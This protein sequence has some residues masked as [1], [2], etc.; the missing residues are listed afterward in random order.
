MSPSESPRLAVLMTCHN[1]KSQTQACLEALKLQAEFGASLDVYLVDD[2]STDGTAAAASAVFPQIN[3][4]RGDGDLYWCG[5]MRLAFAAA[6]KHNYDFYLWL[7]D[8]TRLF[9]DA[10]T[11]LL[12]THSQAS[13]SL[14]QPTIVVGSTCDQQTGGM[15]YGGWI[16]KD[17]AF[18]PTSWRKI[19][20]KPSHWRS[21]DTINGNCVLIPRGV[22]ERIGNLDAHFIHGIGDLD[23]GLRSKKSGCQIVISAG[24]L[25]AC[26]V[27]D[28]TGLWSDA[29]QP[30]GV[31]WNKLLG[32]KGLPVK[33]W[34]VFCYRH[35]GIFWPLVWLSPYFGFW[36]NELIHLL[37]FSRLNLGSR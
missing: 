22:V 14:K 28:G 36:S 19:A 35:K 13:A 30:V 27:N 21:C 24:Y 1:R 15:T 3:I 29:R 5:G 37:G 20:P 4:I 26:T 18:G 32:P 23:Y 9:E 17:R 6:M 25:G 7:N 16:E 34:F 10:L 2:G 12:T 31:R 11:R 33:A 8:D